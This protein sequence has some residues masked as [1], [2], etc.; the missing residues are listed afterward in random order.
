MRE[1]FLPYCKPAVGEE[2]IAAV[3][4]ALRNGWL[5]TGPQTSA[6]EE[7]FARAS[8]VQN[9]VALNSCTAGLHLALAAL[10]IGQ[11]DEIVM[12]SL[13]FVAGAQCAIEI[14][15]RPV[16]C[17]VDP[18]TFSL[19]LRTVAPVVTARTK[20]IIAM[21]YAGRPL[22]IAEIC[23]FARRRGIVVLEDAAH[24]AGTLDRGEWPGSRS[25]AAVYSFYATKNLTTGEGGMLVTN[26][27][28]LAQRVRRLSLHGMSRDAW[29]RY[30]NGGSWR[31]D[32]LEPGYK[33]NMPDLAASIGLVQLERLASLQRRRDQ[34]AA[35][36]LAGLAGLPGLSCQRL[37]DHAGDRHS[38][39]MFAIL[40]DENA[41][42]IDRETL[43][44]QLRALNVGTSVHYIPTHA[45]TAYRSLP[46]VPLPQTDA[47]AKRIL[48][49]PL[50][51]EM[52]DDD[53]ADVTEAIRSILAG[54]PATA[55]ASS[56][57]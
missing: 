37:P 35:R 17:D 29:Q 36:Y 54:R 9:A 50:Y 22:G 11:G 57:I 39:C 8:G 18:E 1:S 49:L 40:V 16:L 52:T 43:V 45:F 27:R 6:F 14:G 5:T 21:P 3:A 24:C 34:I 19:S 20:V 26:N 31:Y 47:I 32:V 28:S 33:Y 41:A 51:P 48:S 42:G 38:W 13:T 30:S 23:D 10:E 55:A 44:D 4:R 53:V 56:A 25:D 7:A 2:E 12:P 15:A 46:T